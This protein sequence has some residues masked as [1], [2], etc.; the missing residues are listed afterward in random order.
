MAPLTCSRA[1][2]AGGPDRFTPWTGPPAPC[3]GAGQSERSSAAWSP[4]ASGRGYQDVIVPTT[5]GAFVL[6]GRTGQVVAA[7]GPSL[8][9]QG[10]PLVT[11]DPNG[12]IGITLAGYN[13][14]DQGEVEHFEMPG[15]AT[16]P[17]WRPRGWPMFHHDPQLTGN[18]GAQ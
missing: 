16:A 4:P 17:P 8:G 14:Y 18:A 6:D 11:R 10:A 5:K 1:P 15:L 7:L 13:G 2:T 9:L 3:S 12:T